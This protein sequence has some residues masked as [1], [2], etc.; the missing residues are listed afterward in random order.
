MAAECVSALKAENFRIFCAKPAN[1]R[2]DTSRSPKALRELDFSLNT[3][4]RS[5]LQVLFSYIQSDVDILQLVFG[6]EHSGISSEMSDLGDGD[7][8]IPMYGLT[9]SLNVSVAAAICVH[10][11]RQAR[12][13]A[14]GKISDLSP[15]ACEELLNEY[16]SM[17]KQYERRMR[18][19]IPRP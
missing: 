15:E 10:W 18:V 17:G 1:P 2:N 16:R 12:E 14:L 11:G 9:E 6:N 8:T 19:G 4:V 5:T 7:F 3:A 13:A